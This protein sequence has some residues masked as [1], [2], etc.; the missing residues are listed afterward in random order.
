MAEALPL[1][2]RRSMSEDGRRSQ[3][4]A[5]RMRF[6]AKTSLLDDLRK[7]D[8]VA[9][10]ELAAIRCPTLAVYGADSICKSGGA[11]IAAQ[12]AG[13]AVVELAGG[14]FLPIDAPNELGDLIERF[15]D[16]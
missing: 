8:R 6:F 9:D 13:A 2:L 10:S 5:D 1:P 11:R 4:F 15:I 3:R 12:V 16:G 14:H 7:M